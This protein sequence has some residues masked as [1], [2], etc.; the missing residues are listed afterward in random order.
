MEM[1]LTTLLIGFP[2]GRRGG[3]RRPRFGAGEV[4]VW[5]IERPLG[6]CPHV[7]WVSSQFGTVKESQWF[8]AP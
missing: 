4:Q 2:L 8:L 7:P 6:F 1:R 5:L 3:A